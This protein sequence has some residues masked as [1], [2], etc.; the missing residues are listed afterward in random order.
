MRPA[1]KFLVS[2]FVIGWQILLVNIQQEF[3]N[4]FPL[5]HVSTC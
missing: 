5:P 1:L 2:T 3:A 4:I